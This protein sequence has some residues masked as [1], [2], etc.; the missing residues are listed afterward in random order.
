MT[1]KQ[2]LRQ[3]RKAQLQ[4]Q[5]LTEEIEERR[6]AI[7]ST[8]APIL[9]DRVQTSPS[10]HFA[11]AMAQLM[12][13]DMRRAEEMLDYLILKDRISEQVRSIEPELY[14]CDVAPENSRGGGVQLRLDLPR[15][16]RCAPGVFKK[17]PDE[18][19]TTY[20]S[21][22]LYANMLASEMTERASLGAG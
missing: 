18:M 5:R 6:T 16:R 11:A 8:A 7:T 2:Y 17:V 3:V 15:S 4:I 19:N 21:S 20:K 12:D 14:Q 22:F 1:A 10:D 13:L 9:G